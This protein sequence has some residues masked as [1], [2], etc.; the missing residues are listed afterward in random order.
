[1]TEFD[2]T[3][4]LN[5]IEGGGSS[6]EGADIIMEISG[7]QIAGHAGVNRFFG[8]F[9]QGLVVGPIGTTM[10]A[11]PPHQM[12]QEQQFLDL[13]T[14]AESWVVEGG[15]LVVN[16]NDLSAVFAPLIGDLSGG[17]WQ[18][19][20]YNNGTGGFTTPV[21]GTLVTAEFDT[22]GFVTGSAGCNSYRGRYELADGEISLGPV[23]S[24]KMGCPDEKIKEQESRYLKILEEVDHLGFSRERG[25]DY[26]EFFDKEGLRLIQFVSS[27]G[28]GTDHKV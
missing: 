28:Q 26:V 14:R 12:K 23:M 2:G 6:L 27:H 17:V 9:A 11:G 8:K 20:G 24:T 16:A 15:S 13:I 10:M 3:W 18:L 25:R 4:V 5:A 7:D 22:E 19:S 1:M 21:P